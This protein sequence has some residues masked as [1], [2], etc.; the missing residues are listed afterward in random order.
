M[1][2]RSEPAPDRVEH[3]YNCRN[4]NDCRETGV[5]ESL[6]RGL[7]LLR[8]GPEDVGDRLEPGN[9]RRRADKRQRHDRYPRVL[10]L[11]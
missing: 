10:R 7:G 4:H 6:K 3:Y 1:A 11:A 8:E 5:D 2:P 9:E